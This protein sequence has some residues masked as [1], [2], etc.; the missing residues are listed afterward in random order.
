MASDASPSRVA[1]PP[2]RLLWLSIAAALMTITLKTT[3]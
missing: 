2:F 3:A 1:Q